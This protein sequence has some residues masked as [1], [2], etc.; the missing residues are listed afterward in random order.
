LALIAVRI[1]ANNQDMDKH[2]SYSHS[3]DPGK[4]MQCASFLCM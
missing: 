1:L 2:L 4:C 3:Y